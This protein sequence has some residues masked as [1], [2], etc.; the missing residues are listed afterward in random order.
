MK[1]IDANAETLREPAPFR[2]IHMAAGGI[3]GQGSIPQGQRI[4][5]LH[6]IAAPIFPLFFESR[7]IFQYLPP[8]AQIHVELFQCFRLACPGNDFFLPLRLV[9]VQFFL[10][11]FF[12]LVD[13]L[14]AVHELIPLLFAVGRKHLHLGGQI[15]LLL[16]RRGP[17]VI[18]PSPQPLFQQPILFLVFRQQRSELRYLLFQKFLLF[19][20][21]C[22]IFFLMRKAVQ[23]LIHRIQIRHEL[24]DFSFP[25]G[26]SNE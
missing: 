20:Q 21:L 6:E 7:H 2:P 3:K 10:E 13:H 15:Q 26:R 19:L 18:F 1:F 25:L 23:F 14:H 16:H 8:L 5:Q 12:L 17:F 4:A 24:V 9:G 22:E 11:R